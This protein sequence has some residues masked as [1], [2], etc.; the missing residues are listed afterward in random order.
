[1][2]ENLEK[3]VL[4]END[5]LAA[6]LRQRYREQ[7]ILCVNF[8]SSP[9]SGKT[10]LLEKTLASFQPGRP[11]AVLT[12]DLQTDN[13]ARRL[14]KFGFPVRQIVTGG[15]CHL[16]ARMVDRH[17]NELGF[18]GPG[19]L[20]VENVGNLVCPSSYDLGEAAKIVL[21]SVT[22]GEDKPLKY[23]GIFR[24]SSLMI[25]TK[26][27]LLPHVDFQPELAFENAHKIHPEMET[28]ALSSRTGEGFEKWLHWL[29]ALQQKVQQP[30]AATNS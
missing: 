18:H 17:L 10:A 23:P 14:A 3:K 6:E 5:R 24:R 15:T 2:R 22:E 30:L 25:L 28:I 21:L 8:I 1:M 4:S 16:D 27:D 19:L 7:N 12:G 13:D 20:L 9:G 11:V 26:I 29:D